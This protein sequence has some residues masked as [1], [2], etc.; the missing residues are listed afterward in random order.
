MSD[1]HRAVEAEIDAFR[2]N[3]IPPFS[4]LLHRRRARDR[5]IRMAGVAA[6]SAVAVAGVVFLPFTLAGGSDRVE[7]NTS[8]APTAPGGTTERGTVLKPTHYRLQYAEFDQAA[9]KAQARAAQMRAVSAC[10]ALKGVATP[11]TRYNTQIMFAT[12]TGSTEVR[13]FERCIQQIEGVTLTVRPD[14]PVPEPSPDEI[15]FDP[16]TAPDDFL[17]RVPLPS[18]GSFDVGL[19]WQEPPSALKCLIDAIGSDTGAEL[20]LSGRTVEGDPIVL[21]YR[22]LPGRHVI[23]VFEDSTRDDLGSQAWASR[24]CRDFDTDLGRPTGCQERDIDN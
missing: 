20:A 13:S 2:P 10:F 5:R 17:T 21:Y 11:I 9:F 8:Q 15:P 7:Q 22:A 24:T 1:L 19:A 6:M 16:G 4:L 23:E 18:C 3:R 14:V 12:V